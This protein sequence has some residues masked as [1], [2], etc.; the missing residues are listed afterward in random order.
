MI[1]Q[2]QDIQKSVSIS[3]D[4]CVVGSGAGGATVAK[5]LREAGYQVVLIEEGGYF[6]T[7]DYRTDDTIWST[8]HLYR[9]AGATAI[10][11]KP[12]IMYAEGRCLGGSTTVNGGMCW[13]TPEKIMKRWQWEKRMTDFSPQKM[14]RYFSRAEGIINASPIIPEAINRDSQLLKLGAEKAGYEVRANLRSAKTCVGANMCVMGCPTGAKQSTLQSYIPLYL[15]NGGE[16]YTNCRVQRVVTKRGRAIG[17]DGYFVDPI[18]KKRMHKFKV[19]SKVVVVSCG[20]VQTPALLMKS[21]I[22]SESK[23]LGKNLIT[24]P[25]AKVLAVFDEPVYAWKGVNQG[26]QI[27]EFF[28]EGILM[29]VNFAP[30]SIAALALPHELPNPMQIL[31]D[32]FHH[33]VMGAAL[34]ED[35][36]RG[37]VRVGP[38]G[39]VLPFYNLNSWDF[40]RA[41]R[42]VSLL[43]E[44]FFKAG[45][46]K[47]YLPFTGMPEIQS[48]DEIPKIFEKNLK[49]KDI[50]LMTV[51]IMGTAQM[52]G[53]PKRSVINT[54]GE[55]HGVKG[56]FVADASVFPTSI[57][58]N[59]QLTIM[60]LATRTAE[61][62]ANQFRQY[63]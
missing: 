41:V 1:H 47:C 2:Y 60:A 63:L 36:S 15:N 6:D 53:D 9:D 22:K 31:K 18:T 51:H 29:A 27:T 43:T 55:F 10:V 61:Y 57:G 19:R 39:T 38:M 28:E 33:M 13:R 45:A 49:P 44:V 40:E 24:H 37:Q 20:A 46:R 21:G 30:P 12:S 62:I 34:I 42:A 16:V 35:T 50:E 5:E 52:G 54:H 59:P 32:E 14:D 26:F 17:V 58:V 23:L 11:G 48:I 4:V 3:A 25:N 7:K 56:L 8:T